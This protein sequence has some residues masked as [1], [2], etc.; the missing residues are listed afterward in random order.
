MENTIWNW[1]TGVIGGLV[2]GAAL[3][4]SVKAQ[5]PASG[6][7]LEPL[8][9]REV[10]VTTAKMTNL[11][12]P[13][14]VGT[15]VKV[16]RDVLVQ[17]VHGAANVLELKAARPGFR[18]TNLS[19]YTLDG[20][21]YS[22]DLRY[23]EDTGV[24]NYRVVPDTSAGWEPG[25]ASPRPSGWPRRLVIP[26]GLPVDWVSLQADADRLGAAPGFMR[27]SVKRDGLVVTL[28]GIWMTDSLLWL[29]MEVRNRSLI[30]YRPEYLRVYTEDRKKVR[31]MAEQQAPV[32][33]VLTSSLP[34]VAGDSI[35]PL[36][37][38]FVPFSVPRGKWLC[39]D[40]A[41]A[42]GGRQTILRIDHKAL[43][44]ARVEGR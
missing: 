17:K 38:G 42:G 2:G 8:P 36:V 33:P 21:L 5:G 10:V 37:M 28:R 18:T 25:M 24:L 32:S 6:F 39:V 13:V 11:V 44:R 16:S 43:L 20:N 26:D 19:V 31:R 27:H 9:S 3:I 34:L 15:G 12:F 22:F 41:D 29:S 35:R 7:H 30:P 14:A 23:V 4:G 1:V 40:M